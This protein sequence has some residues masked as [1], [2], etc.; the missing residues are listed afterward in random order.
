MPGSLD[1]VRACVRNIVHVEVLGHKRS[2]TSPRVLSLFCGPS[3][4]MMLSFARMVTVCGVPV[5]EAVG[6]WLSKGFVAKGIGTE[7]LYINPFRFPTLGSYCIRLGSY[8]RA[9]SL[10]APCSLLPVAL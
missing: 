10:R 6:S 1:L 3:L 5:A 8:M 2:R 9:G 7:L 4:M